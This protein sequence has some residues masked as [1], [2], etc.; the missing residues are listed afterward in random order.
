MV[1]ARLRVSFALAVTAAWTASAGGCSTQVRDGME[2]A[3]RIGGSAT[4]P[5]VAELL[6]PNRAGYTEWNDAY[7]SPGFREAAKGERGSLAA[8]LPKVASGSLVLGPGY[9]AP[10]RVTL[11][12]IG[13]RASEGELREGRVLYKDAYEGVD[14]I[15]VARP[16]IAE[17]FY[18]L[19]SPRSVHE[20]SW[21]VTLPSGVQKVDVRPDGAWFLDAQDGFVLRVPSPFYLDARGRKGGARLRFDQRESVLSIDVA[22]EEAD[23]YPLLLDPAFETRFW[24]ELR[25]PYGLTR[26]N[27]VYDGARKETVLFGDNQTWTWDGVAWTEHPPGRA[28]VTPGVRY[29]ASMVFD[30]NRAEA[31]FYGGVEQDGRG[32]DTTWRWNGV[33]WKHLNTTTGPPGRLRAGFVYDRGG[34]RGIHFGGQASLLDYTLSDETWTWDGTDWQPSSVTGVKPPKRA[35]HGMAYDE[36]RK[37]VVIFGGYD[38]N[39]QRLSDTWE[40]AN[41][42]WTRVTTADVE[43]KPPPRNAAAMAYDEARQR[44]VLF[45]GAG[46]NGSLADT[47]T[48][49]GT[50]WKRENPPLSPP[51]MEDVAASYDR[52]AK[53]VFVSGG[54]TPVGTGRN[55]NLW[56]WDGT[57]WRVERVGD[58]PQ[59]FGGRPILF[60]HP[61]RKELLHFVGG[62]H[63]DE[64]RRNDYAWAHSGR[65]WSSRTFQAAP[66]QRLLADMTFDAGRGNTVLFGGAWDGMLQDTWVYKNAAWVPLFPAT[67]P[68][69]RVQHRMAYHPASNRVVLYGGVDGNGLPGDTWLWDG[70]TWSASQPQS[71]PSPRTGHTLALHAPSGKLLLVGGRNANGQTLNE[72]WSWNGTTWTNLQPALMPDTSTGALLLC[73]P[74]DCFLATGV[75]EVFRW[76]ETTWKA[77]PI[78]GGY[79]DVSVLPSAV[80]DPRLD[81]FLVSAKEAYSWQPGVSKFVDDGASFRG[82]PIAWT[83]TTT[84]RF[85]EDDGS[86]NA[87][88]YYRDL[89]GWVE[90]TS[91]KIFPVRNS[92]AAF[93]VARN[94]GVLVGQDFNGAGRIWTWDGDTMHLKADLPAMA[95]GAGV[96]MA[97]LPSAAHMVLFGDEGPNRDATRLWDG[98]SLTT[99]I[100]PANAPVPPGRYSSAAAYDPKS[101]RVILFGGRDDAGVLGDTW[102]WDGAKWSR[103]TPEVSPT[104]RA[105][106]AMTYSPETG[107]VLLFGGAIATGEASD[108]WSWNGSNWS[109]IVTKTPP[110]SRSSHAFAHAT[111]AHRSIVFGGTSN[112]AGGTPTPFPWAFYARGGSCTTDAECGTAA[113]VDGVCCMVS[114]CGTCQTCAGTD[115]GVCTPVRN[116]EDPD[117]CS[118][119]NRVSCN[120]FGQCGPALGGDCKVGSDCGSG[121]C[122]DGVC[123]DTACDRPCEACKAA[124]KANGKEDGR[125]GTARAGSNPSKRCVG[126]AT[127]SSVGVCEESTGTLC[128]D[129]R[130]IRDLAG[131]Q[132]DCAPYR[133]IGKCLTRCS[134]AN[135]CVFPA[136]CDPSGVCSSAGDVVAED[137]GGCA[138]VARASGGAAPISAFA[139]LLVAAAMRRRSSRRTR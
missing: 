93:D 65:D 28:G 110:P 63:P 7:A 52:V 109:L 11:T 134:S 115:P 89:Q 41:Q 24:S 131:G 2:S 59:Q 74:A 77:V 91:Q 78:E 53:R 83:G 5:V 23:A 125:C 133:C 72:T 14:E 123:C 43:P 56:S 105:E 13:A 104:A 47:W 106:H 97:Y 21:R 22:R 32:S 4:D 38:I 29:A 112:Q 111:F 66:P 138:F 113:C 48:F 26:P 10:F 18:V 100:P 75:N 30:D 25:A 132:K 16:S 82:G 69:P 130:Y 36:A 42:V 58:L 37:R 73:N 102:A 55:N 35:D 101:G 54:N 98:T 81:K 61:Q 128:V 49:D 119:T 120:E 136:T 19:A 45:G 67:R 6:A 95:S 92:A 85:A 8:L 64:L 31:I 15:A 50:R 27:A 68:S 3:L 57:T 107:T 79:W 94:I 62:A 20:F 80:W 99:W 103:L 116:A 9:V 135:D 34:Q 51:P 17:Q 1:G 96:A 33:E 71:S 137:A 88:T 122:V 139:L 114:A 39:S 84:L 40:L 76:D 126:A 70:Q 124:D 44:V 121:N 129:G 87:G 60:E 127:C 12:P 90:A 118:S 86:T 108:L 117:T 46:G